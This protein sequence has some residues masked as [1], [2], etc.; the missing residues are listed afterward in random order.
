V[1]SGR[2]QL[3]TLKGN[4]MEKAELIEKIKGLLGPQGEKP[5]ILHRH[6]RVMM[7]GWDTVTV[8][9][10]PRYYVLA[11]NPGAEEV[12]PPPAGES[13]GDSLLEDQDGWSYWLDEAEPHHR[14]RFKS[15]MEGLGVEPRSVPVSN[16]LFL[17]GRGVETYPQGSDAA[18]A[19]HCA[20]VHELL[21]GIVEPRVVVCFGNDAWRFLVGRPSPSHWR[22]NP[23]VS[24]EAAGIRYSCGVLLLPHFAR[25]G[26]AASKRNAD[27]LTQAIADARKYAEQPD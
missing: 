6:G 21:L 26:P 5:G 25:G 16:A 3:D 17:R 14:E 24:F 15:V 7:S 22:F 4:R 2:A 9:P 12:D 18:F 23:D 11:I 19:A 27:T 20:P 1:D 8:R 13:V 10:S